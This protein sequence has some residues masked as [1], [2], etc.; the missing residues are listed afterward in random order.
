METKKII[1]LLNDSSNEQICYN[2]WCVIDSQ[3]TKGKCDEKHSIKF[4]TGSIK[5]NF[6]EYSRPFTLVTGDI[7]VAAK[8]NTDVAFK[9]YAPFSACKPN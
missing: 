8:N 4:E 9:N 6:C 1:N 3:T 5:S 7:T 2:K